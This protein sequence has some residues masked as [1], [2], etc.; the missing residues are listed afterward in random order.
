MNRIVSFTDSVAGRPAHEEEEASIDFH[1]FFGRC[2][3]EQFGGAAGL[4]AKS[5]CRLGRCPDRLAEFG[6]Q[7]VRD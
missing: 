5:K 4:A 1:P 7:A 3:V 6:C 2:E